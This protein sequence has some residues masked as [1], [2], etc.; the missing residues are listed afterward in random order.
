MASHGEDLLGSQ[1]SRVEGS[2]TASIATS[3]TSHTARTT[4]SCSLGPSSQDAITSI[5]G[6][7][8][9]QVNQRANLNDSTSCV[10]FLRSLKLGCN[11][12][13]QEHWRGHRDAFCMAFTELLA[14][15]TRLS[16]VARPPEKRS[17]STIRIQEDDS[18]LP[19]VQDLLM[20]IDRAGKKYYR[21]RNYNNLI[22][23][24]RPGGCEELSQR[25][26]DS[27]TGIK[28]QNGFWLSML[29]DARK[30]SLAI[31]KLKRLHDVFRAND[32]SEFSLSHDPK[33]P[34]PANPD[35]PT[36]RPM[37]RHAVYGGVFEDGKV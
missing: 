14:A 15:Q 21:F 10:T 35:T 19:P 11:L 6:F 7:R 31:I 9:S 8:A 16:N 3:V 34:Q 32:A 37:K 20:W 5:R 30:V 26:P 2:H 29:S 23:K 36:M 27:S 28:H 1:F 12:E 33:L 13:E 4:S 25:S 22:S 17:W 18:R 24:L